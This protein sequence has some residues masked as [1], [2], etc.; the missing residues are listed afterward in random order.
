MNPAL[1][2]E[3]KLALVLG[4]VGGA[5]SLLDA[6][7]TTPV[8]RPHMLG[9]GDFLIDGRD[10]ALHLDAFDAELRHLT[11]SGTTVL[12]RYASGPASMQAAFNSCIADFAAGVRYNRPFE[13][14][15]E[16]NLKTLAITL[17]LYESVSRGTVVRPED[18]P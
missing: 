10:G 17:A 5:T 14:S 18:A 16:D 11:R 12:Q 13:S 7:W 4:H 1:E 6:S 9:Q 2:G 3:S 15:A 8:E